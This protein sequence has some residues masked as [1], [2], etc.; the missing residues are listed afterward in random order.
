[1]N[2]CAKVYDLKRPDQHLRSYDS[3]FKGNVTSVGCFWKQENVI[4]TGCEDGYLRLFDI[5]ARNCFR[6]FK[7]DKPIN[8]SA[9]HPTEGSIVT[10]DEV[11]I[12]KW[13]DLANG[14][15]MMK[16]E[17]DYSI[18]S[19]TISETLERMAIGDNE[20]LINCYG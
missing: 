10:G 9:L 17:V 8:C 12:V 18:R 7:H 1:M 6:S 13:W 16:I 19:I 15:E 4:Y 20:G 14:K 2:N 3:D 5:R 11:G